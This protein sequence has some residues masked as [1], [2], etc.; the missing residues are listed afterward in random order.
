[1]RSPALLAVVLGLALTATPVRA[2]IGDHWV[3]AWA[4][5][6]HRSSAA[7]VP[8]TY[9]DQTIRMV[10]RM[11]GGGNAVRVRLS[12]AHGDRPVTFGA[13]TVA[14]RE[15]GAALAEGT[16]RKAAFSGA[17]SVTVPAGEVVDSDP[18]R[19]RVLEGQDLA[20]SVYVPEATGP[21]TWHRSA[22][23]TNYLSAPGDHTGD[24]DGG[25]YPATVRSWLFLDAVAVT[26]G[27]A[28][29]TLVAVGDSITDGSGTAV[30]GF[31]RWPDHLAAR[32]AAEQGR[33]PAVVNTGIGGNR[34]RTDTAQDG[35]SLLNRLERDVL[36]RSG[37]THVILLHGVNDLRDRATADQ[38]IAAYQEVVD[39]V[40]ARGA[41][42][43]GG[44]ITPFKGGS[45]HT[46]TA[47]AHRQAV[48]AWITT[49]GA[50][51]GVIDFAAAVADPADPQALDPAYDRGDHL[52]PNAAGFAAMAQAVDLSL[53]R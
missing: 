10:V 42:I 21:A 50:F 39:R 53:F 32:F 49:S 22:V 43:Y 48:N 33:H 30:D 14:L 51:D 2:D 12:N 4:T 38:L 20:V 52:H 11:R 45:A 27:P 9:D 7:A 41:K 31:E 44:T 47:E 15:S 18:V 35:Q 1:M 29:G 28:P 3:D 24:L 36:S 13:V 26:H 40:H 46:A 17:P 25:T 6:L 16:L 8:P 34:V 19:L 23:Q 37:L 5:S